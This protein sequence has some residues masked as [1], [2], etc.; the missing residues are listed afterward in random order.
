MFEGVSDERLG[1]DLSM[2]WGLP[3]GS[4]VRDGVAPPGW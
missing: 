3:W 1:V 4:Q 2:R